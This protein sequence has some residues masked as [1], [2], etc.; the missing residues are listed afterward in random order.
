[1]SNSISELIESKRVVVCCGAGGVGKTTVSA[2]IAL[3]AARAGQ[4]VVVVTIDPSKRLA[5]SLGISPNQAAP[6]ELDGSRWGIEA[7]GSLSAWLLDPKLVADHVVRNWSDDKGAADKLLGNRIYEAAS[8][9]ISGMQEYTA[10]EALHGFVIDG[11]Y[12]L[13]VLDTPPSRNALR[14]L[15]SPTRIHQVLNPRVFKLFLPSSGG[16]LQ[17]GARRVINGVLDLGLG[18]TQRVEFQEFLLLFQGILGHLKHNQDEVQAFFRGPEVSFLLVS[19][20]AREAVQEA[21]YFEQKT[22]ELDLEL[23]G[24]VLNRSMA[25][26]QG[27]QMPGDVKLPDDAPDA[28][29]SA[30]TK[31]IPLAKKE[32][33][34]VREHVGLAHELE[35]RVGKDGI[36]RVL[37]QLAGDAGDA[38]ALMGLSRMLVSA[39]ST[40]PPRTG[41]EI[42]D[43][44]PG[45]RPMSIPPPDALPPSESWFPPPDES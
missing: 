19:S 3:A 27:H 33:A 44:G 18:K 2:S 38:E 17:R 35:D 6:V 20:P 39:G 36:V 25:W 21:F 23:G 15:D 31:L 7:P 41:I 10:V 26:A 16:P 24:Y 34:L 13:V 4:R 12:D 22:R 1:M 11:R 45:G 40:P 14:F 28:L 29:R 32:Q 5:E 43:G 42:P 8:N 9:M 30:L 37:P